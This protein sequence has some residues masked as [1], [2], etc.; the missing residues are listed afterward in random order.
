MMRAA[1]V[2]ERLNLKRYQ[3]SWRGRCPCCD[4]AANTFCIRAGT[5]GRAL[6]FCANGCTR[7]ELTEAVARATGHQLGVQPDDEHDAARR[8]R[9]RERALAL[10]RGSESAIGTLADHYLTA[11]GLPGLAASWPFGFAVIRHTLKVGGH[12]Q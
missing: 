9:N 5:K 11:R 10:W 2:A 7:Q 3:Q 4:Y 1:E 12:L 8:E 6:L